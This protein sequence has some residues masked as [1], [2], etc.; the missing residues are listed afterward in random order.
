LLILTGA[1]GLNYT[2]EFISYC[3]FYRRKVTCGIDNLYTNT[4]TVNIS[5]TANVYNY[6]RVRDITKPAVLD[7]NSAALLTDPH[8][9][10]KQTHPVF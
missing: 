1:T 10:K 3:I 4:C 6:I 5:N 2:T 8:E 9:S 7:E